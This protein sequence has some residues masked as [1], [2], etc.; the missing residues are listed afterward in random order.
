MSHESSERIHRSI[1]LA[2]AVGLA[3][4][5]AIVATFARNDLEIVLYSSLYVGS[6]IAFWLGYW[7]LQSR[8]ERRRK[9]LLNG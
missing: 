5:I 3:I 9:E 1:V 8:T 6:V 7:L 4:V 2:G